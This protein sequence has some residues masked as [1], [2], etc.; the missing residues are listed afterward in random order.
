MTK[1]VL[2][3]SSTGDVPANLAFTNNFAATAAPASGNDS[4]QG[5][6]PGSVWI[7][8]NAVYKCTN[9]AAGAAVWVVCSDGETTPGQVLAPNA[10]TAT[11]AGGAALVRGGTGGSTSGAGGASSLTGGAATAGNS[12]GGA[13]AM[14]G[15]TGSGNAAGGAATETAGAGGATGNGGVASITGGAGGATSGNGGQAQ[16]TGGAATAGNGNGGSVVITGGALNGSG[17]NGM[18][19]E[20]S[21]GLNFQAAEVAH[22]TAATLAASDL[23]GALITSAPSGAINLQL[24]LATAMDT[25]APDSIANDSLDFSVIN[26]SGTNASTI[27]TNTGWTLVGSMVVPGTG[28]AA[29]SGRFRARKTAAGAWTLYR[30]A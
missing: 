3:S 26:T 16:V 7:F 23:L 30:L 18:V 28:T 6:T 22:N 25:A 20:R 21:I 10:A 11:S 14:T 5:Y 24:P 12:A 13:A 2:W 8:G 15:G 4:T 1:L 17:V 9:A 29:A 19:I 27:T